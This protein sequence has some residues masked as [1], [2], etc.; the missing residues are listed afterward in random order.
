MHTSYIKEDQENLVVEP[1]RKVKILIVDDEELICWSLKHSFEKVKG[2]HVNCAH[3]GSDA[4]QE[5][6]ENRYDIVITDLNLPDVN[7]FN[8]VRKIKNIASD[9]PV[10]V[11]SASLCGPFLDEVIKQGAY[12]CFNK[13]FE[14]D[15]VLYEVKEA[16]RYNIAVQ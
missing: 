2:Y 14:I 5:L 4:L 3:T 16:V 12:K 1:V 7:D 8:I 6:H 9:T 10:I 13:P 15:T 11:I